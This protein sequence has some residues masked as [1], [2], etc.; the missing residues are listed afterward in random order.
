MDDESR[1][2]SPVP[3]LAPSAVRRRWLITISECLGFFTLG[4]V[5]ALLGPTLLDLAHQTD[6]SIAGIGRAFTA[7]SVGYLAGSVLG[8]YLFD[9]MSNPCLVLA[10]GLAITGLSTFL[11]PFCTALAAIYVVV[12]FQGAAMGFLDTGGNVLLLSM[13]GKD[14]G[15]QMQAMHFCF[16][17]GAFISPMIASPFISENDATFDAAACGIG[18]ANGTN[19]TADDIIYNGDVRWPYWIATMIALPVAALFLV[20][21]RSIPA[22]GEHSARASLD[23]VPHRREG[24]YRDGVLLLTFLF[25]MFY[26][27]LEVSYGGYVFSYA[28]KDCDI[29]MQPTTAAY[30][31]SVFWGAFALGRLLAV[32]L[33]MRVPPA[34]MTL[35]DLLG[36][37]AAT[38]ILISTQGNAGALW[39]ASA[40]Y[41]M[42][43]ASIFPSAYHLVEYFIDVTARA[44]SFIVVGASLGEMVLPLITSA[45][46]DATGP[47]S[48]LYIMF[49]GT[50][51]AT[52]L[53]GGF[54]AWGFLYRPRSDEYKAALLDADSMPMHSPSSTPASPDGNATDETQ[55]LDQHVHVDDEGDEGDVVDHAF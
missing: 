32:F 28:V 47:P 8:G 55:L 34:V 13:W 24:R 9:H 21:S 40:I 31:T 27:G 36:C 54:V 17:L 30:L 14:C 16:G 39:A 5:L 22:A 19:A 35:L 42:S 20:M 52:A 38:V 43:M 6:A 48:F 18:P 45:L 33:A 51:V 50:L 53:F 29:A 11:V 3:A 37:I 15:P 23:V 25:L 2:A 41:G 49:A 26:V 4:V 10:G 7:R 44:A 1:P 12:S 46:F